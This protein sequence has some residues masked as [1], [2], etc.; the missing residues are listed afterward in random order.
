MNKNIL[1]IN[2]HPNINPL[3]DLFEELNNWDYSFYLL[4]NDNKLLAKFR[5]KNW[6]AKKIRLGLNLTNLFS[7]VV[8]LAFLPLWYLFALGY[9]LYFK[10]NKKVEFVICFNWPEKLIITVVAKILQLRVFWLEC[11]NIDYPALNRAL[12]NFYKL[13][14]RLVQIITLNNFT[15]TQLINFGLKPK[16]IYPVPLGIKLSRWQHQENIFTK[17]AQAKQKNLNRKFFTIGTATQL[18][19]KKSFEVLFQAIQ[20]CLTVIPSLQLIVVGEGPERKNLAWLAKKMEIDTFVWFVGEQIYLKKWLDNFDLF[21][22]TS[23]ILTLGDLNT[24]LYA[25]LAGLPIIG[26]SHIGLEDIIVHNKNGLLVDIYDGETL[27][28]NIIKLEQNLRWRIRLGQNGKEIVNK[29][30]T[31]NKMV[32]RFAEII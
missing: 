5:E 32:K 3:F 9:L 24:A 15:K 7:V 12:K 4:T 18:D 14:S 27:A 16:N 19:N 25:L 21:V 29:F 28:Q 20:K 11:P 30:F 2:T 23:K 8:F 26:P 10:A 31:L 13:N 17:M 1:I 22:F 6:F